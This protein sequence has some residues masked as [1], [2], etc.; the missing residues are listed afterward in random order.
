MLTQRLF[1]MVAAEQGAILNLSKLV[2]QI[3]TARAVRSE[4]C[5]AYFFRSHDG[6]EA[7]L[8]IESGRAR[9]VIEIRLTSGPTPEDL[10]RLAQVADLIQATRQ[11]LLCR[12]GESSTTGRRWVTNLS[13]YLRATAEPEDLTGSRAA[14]P[15]R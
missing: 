7:D 12:V 1:R 9:E 2:E 13:D 11:V 8:V 3:L 10:A 6:H 15:K 14:A 4:G 5:D